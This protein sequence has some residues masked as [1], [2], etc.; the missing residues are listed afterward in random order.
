MTT[1]RRGRPP[2]DGQRKTSAEY[3]RAYR[4]RKKQTPTEEKVAHFSIS[5]QMVN[6]LDEIANYFGLSRAQTVNDLLVSTLR[7]ILPVFAQL[8]HEID[9]KLRQY[10]IPPDAKTLAKI[11]ADY[12]K[13]IISINKDE[14]ETSSI[15]DQI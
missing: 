10:P 13:I 7:W 14:H 11:K 6:D 4:E 2:S 3:Q 5:G 9:E 8:P 12:W 15:S 1:K